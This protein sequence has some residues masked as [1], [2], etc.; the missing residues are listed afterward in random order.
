MKVL[1]AR[2][3]T[4]SATYPEPASQSTSSQSVTVSLDNLRWVQLIPAASSLVQKTFVANCNSASCAAT[5][6]S[7]VT[8]GN[9]LVDAALSFQPVTTNIH[10]SY[11]WYATAGIRGPT[12]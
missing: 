2:G 7:S 5:Y 11:I 12:R 8:A 6:S 1:T 10:Y 3:N 4:Y 9:I